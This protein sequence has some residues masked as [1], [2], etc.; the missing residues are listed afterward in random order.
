MIPVPYKVRGNHQIIHVERPYIHVG[1]HMILVPYK[2][3]GTNGYLIHVRYGGTVRVI[4]IRYPF[5]LRYGGTIRVIDSYK[6]PAMDSNLEDI[7]H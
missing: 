5:H 6:V 7:S 3:R 4:D 1:D 2:L